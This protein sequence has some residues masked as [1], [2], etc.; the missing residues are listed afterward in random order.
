M[1]EYE[2]IK[3][4][5]EIAGNIIGHFGMWS[6]ERSIIRHHHERYDGTGYPL[7]VAGSDIAFGA[8]IVAVADAFDAMTSTR[9]Y[10]MAPTISLT[11]G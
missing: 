9:S 10:R 1:R 11:S 4:H 2:I 3:K 7:G 8:R 6:D 5:P